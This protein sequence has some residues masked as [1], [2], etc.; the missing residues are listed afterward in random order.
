MYFPLKQNFLH[1]ALQHVSTA[2]CDVDD[3]DIFGELWIITTVI[4]K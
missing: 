4:N 3:D 2:D 1:R